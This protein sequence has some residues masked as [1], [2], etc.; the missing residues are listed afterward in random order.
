MELIM[1]SDD[2]YSGDNYLETTSL[3]A[4]C[5]VLELGEGEQPVLPVMRYAL[6]ANDA[7]KGK[8]VW[9]SGG[10][11]S[12]A[13]PCI[14]KPLPIF[15]E[16]K[17]A[18][19]IA[20]ELREKLGLDLDKEPLVDRSMGPQCRPKRKVDILLV[21]CNDTASKIATALRAKGKTVDVL[22]SP[23]R[24]VSRHNMEQLA[25]QVRKIILDVDPDLVILQLLDN[26]SFYVNKKMEAGSCRK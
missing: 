24:T 16:K 3:M 6:P 9:A 4:R 25:G 2:F 21:G 23:W 19:G 12:R 15:M 5:I 26:S 20:G 1:W 14:V 17:Y 18:A 13:L 8:R 7:A 22:S 10:Q 11:D